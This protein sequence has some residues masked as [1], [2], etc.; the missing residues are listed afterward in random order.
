VEPVS[1][2]A[3]ATGPDRHSRATD[4]VPLNCHNQF[5]TL[6]PVIVSNIWCDGMNVRFPFRV[7]A[8]IWDLITVFS[9]NGGGF[10]RT[11]LKDET[12]TAGWQLVPHTMPL[13]DSLCRGIVVQPATSNTNNAQ[14]R[15]FAGK[16]RRLSSMTRIRLNR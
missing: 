4:G 8:S 11:A 1:D 7:V 9:H 13:V 6:P 16:A 12:V 15:P 2:A 14:A 5:T 10:V 3:G